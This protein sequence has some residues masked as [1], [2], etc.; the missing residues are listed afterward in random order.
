MSAN[1][2]FVQSK[3][4]V[5]SRLFRRGLIKRYGSRCLVTGCE[6]EALLEAA[7]I[8]PYRNNS[9]NDLSNGLLLRADIHTLFDLY[10]MRIDPVTLTITFNESVRLAGYSAYH[11]QQLQVGNRRPSTACLKIRAG[12][13]SRFDRV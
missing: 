1:K 13:L 4:G 2:F 6:L 5:G 11:G 7:H 10:Q 12:L 9:H 3:F 8:A